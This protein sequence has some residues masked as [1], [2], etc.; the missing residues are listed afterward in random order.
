KNIERQAHFATGILSRKQQHAAKRRNPRIVSARSSGA[1]CDSSL[2]RPGTR[3][4]PR[5][6]VQSVL[7]F[8]RIAQPP[9]LR[10]L[11]LLKFSR[12]EYTPR[13]TSHYRKPGG[14]V[15]AKTVGSWQVAGFAKIQTLAGPWQLATANC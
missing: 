12:N 5:I 3:S 11:G 6:Y 8:G 15:R 10:G 14:Q 4:E 9:T 13:G 1:H 2:M 7:F